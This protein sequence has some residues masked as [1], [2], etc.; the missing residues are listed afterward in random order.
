MVILLLQCIIELY[1]INFCD[2]TNYYRAK[3]KKIRLRHQAESNRSNAATSMVASHSQKSPSR[4]LSARYITALSAIAILSIAG[5]LLIQRS[6]IKHSSNAAIVN[7]AG[8]QRM[9]SQQLS[10]AAIALKVARDPRQRQAR[11]EELQEVVMVWSKSHKA[12]LSG[13]PQLGLPGNNSTRILQMFADLEPH[14]QVMLNGA[15]G[16]LDL[17]S[18]EEANPE[19]TDI[20]SLVDKI[21]AHEAAFLQGMDA[22]VF[23]YQ[24]ETEAHIARLQ[25]IEWLLLGITL[26]VLLL[27]ALFIFEPA[28]KH[29]RDYIQELVRSHQETAQ[30]AAQLEENNTNLD[31]ALQEA[32]SA[33]RLKSEFLANMSHEIRTPMNAV[34]GMTGLLLD[35]ELTPQ[36]QDFVETIR[37]SGDALL[38]IINDILDFSKIEAGKMTLENEPFDLREAI[39]ESLALVA[40]KAAEKKLDLG[41]LLADNTP[42][43]IVT[44][45]TRVR[46]ILVNLLSNAVKFT[47]TGEIVV[48]VSAEEMGNWSPIESLLQEPNLESSQNPVGD[49]HTYYQINFAVKDTGIGIPPEKLDRLFQS[50]S[51]VD[52]STTRKYGGT[53]LGLAIGK[54]LSE[55]MGGR[56]WVESE[57]NVGS[58]FYFNIVAPSAPSQPTIYEKGVQPQ[59]EGKR[60]LIVDDNATNREILRLQTERWGIIPVDV[61]SG[62]EAI[63]CIRRGDDFDLAIVDM[64][65]PEM[66]GITLAIELR[67]YRDADKLPPIVLTSIGCPVDAG[68]I[69]FAGC[70]TKPIKPSVLYE[71][72]MN[73]L[74]KQPK[75]VPAQTAP[76]PQIDDRLGDRFPLRILLAEDNAI[77]QKVALQILRRMGYRADVANNGLEVLE[78]LHRQQYD[79]VLMDVQ[80]PE[81][82][83]LEATRR[84]CQQWEPG[85]RPQIVAM[86]AGAMEGDR[87]KCIE[88]GMDDYITKPIKV[89]ALQAVLENLATDKKYDAIAPTGE[90]PV[91]HPRIDDGRASCFDFPSST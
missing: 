52:A 51:Q 10:K 60:V 91:P 43:S 83:G 79:V 13:D 90:S 63:A 53:G 89:T 78:A 80:M 66:N 85:N 30:L 36:Q 58:T 74:A 88:A 68:Q 22:I 18:V 38:A 75:R 42:G 11:L 70:F 25:A 41:Y 87:D 28:V 21:L 1:P 64:E 77:N 27:E 44:D 56:I 32:Q 57:V 55:L 14:Y 23:Q 31:A 69:E 3:Y 20:S 54:R 24:T 9:L 29:I 2:N 12:L 47:Q 81:M 17:F 15:S 39:E 37:N 16:L 67:K 49:R 59:L 62:A 45:V 86:T 50:F 6:L 40:P 33:T 19:P 84:I 61:S 35:T 76:P 73:V 82:D 72:L 46:Q 26:I 65:M 7:I 71:V 4:R 8:R 5:Q 48:S 34:I